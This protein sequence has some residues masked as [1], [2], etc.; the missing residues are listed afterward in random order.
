MATA[1]RSLRQSSVTAKFA[2][3]SLSC[4]PAFINTPVSSVHQIRTYSFLNDSP[5]QSPSPQRQQKGNKSW[6][7]RRREERSA[8]SKISTLAALE[9]QELISQAQELDTT[10]TG[11]PSSNKQKDNESSRHTSKVLSPRTRRLLL[12][13]TLLTMPLWGRDIVEVV[14]PGT[15]GIIILVAGKVKSSV[16]WVSSGFSKSGR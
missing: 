12:W 8:R 3:R 10:D 7:R 1:I 16:Q 13:A 14:V 9:Q 2:T 5:I 4:G 6:L 11:E 15:L